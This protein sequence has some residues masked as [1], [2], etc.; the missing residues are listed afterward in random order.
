MSKNHWTKSHMPDLTGKVIIVTGGNSGLG[1]ESV[2]A[3]A[4]KGAEVI[5]ACRNLDKGNAARNEIM[6]GSVSG[7]IKVMLLDLAHLDSIR[8]FAIDFTSQ[9]SH[10]NVLLNNAGI[11]TSPYFLTKNDLE[12]QNGI[13]HFGHFALSGRLLDLLKATPGSRIVNVSSNAHKY[14]KMDFGNPLFTNGKGY[15]PMKSYA[16]SKLSNL[17]FTYELDRQFR[18][19]K[20]D[21]KVLAAHPGVAITNLGRYIESKWWFKMFSPLFMGMAQDQAMGALPQIRACIDQEVNGGEYYGP[22]R[23]WEMKGFPVKVTS[24]HASHNEQDARRLW[25]L[26][27][28]ITGISFN[29]N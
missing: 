12:A 4:E 17:L 1:Y 25:K 6:S 20:I 9:Y 29:F 15:S 8:D 11:M 27:E 16:R 24:N 2:K 26:S 3:F 22:D 7:K 28:D 18:N 5:M 23:N 13:N 21:S 19:H 14:G 10:L